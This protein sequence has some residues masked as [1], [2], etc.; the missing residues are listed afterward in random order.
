MTEVAD[1]TAVAPFAPLTLD[2]LFALDLPEITY[3][4]EGILPVG[5]ACLLS[6]REKAGKGLLT[7][8]LCASI[9]LGEPFLD[10]AVAEGPA[11]YAAAEESL[12]DVRA[13]IADRVGA[14]RHAP[15][16]VLPLDGSTGDRL[17]LNDP[18]GMQR[19]LGMIAQMQPALVVL[20]T[21]RELHDRREDL[22]DEMGPLVRPVRQ[23]AHETNTTL[24][25]NHH[26]NKSGGPRGSTA[27]LAA[28]DLGWAFSRT[29]GDEERESRPIRG[30]LRVE[31]RHGP[32]TIM[33]IRLGDGLRWEPDQPVLIPREHGVRER[34]L[35][36]LGRVNAWETAGEIADGSGIKLKT[37]QNV[38]AAMIQEM[39]QPL[40]VQRT[41]TRN[42]PRQ[43]RTRSSHFAGF[44]AEGGE[45][46]IPPAESPIGGKAGGNHFSAA[47]GEAGND[48]Y[49]R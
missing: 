17:K 44:G 5:A 43:Y 26:H 8:D 9:A 11:I 3:L 6:A 20:D 23:L 22:S 14:R 34:I 49:T 16:Y 42:A 40:A 31:G 35:A 15:L 18:E 24:I 41:G 38:L 46:L 39:P 27:I 12:R 37:V 33:S 32:R 25:L 30:T 36:H 13:R 10:R 47:D 29:D 2:E 45:T 7:I 4:V 28:C 48:W 19:L 21:L 1:A